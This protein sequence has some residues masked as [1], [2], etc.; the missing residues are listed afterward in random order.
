LWSGSSRRYHRGPFLAPGQFQLRLPERFRPRLCQQSVSTSPS[1]RYAPHCVASPTLPGELRRCGAEHGEERPCVGAALCSH[2]R[3]HRV[4]TRTGQSRVIHSSS[5]PPFATFSSEPRC[6]GGSGP[7]DD[8]AHG[9]GAVACA[10]VCHV[11]W[12]L[13]RVGCRRSPA[14]GWSCR[15]RPRVYEQADS[16]PENVHTW[17][18]GSVSA[19]TA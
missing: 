15:I 3:G 4:E 6:H 10:A 7:F 9:L 17:P 5:E 11:P 8:L 1:P 13:R 19:S 12:T 14:S 16:L 2:G 18:K